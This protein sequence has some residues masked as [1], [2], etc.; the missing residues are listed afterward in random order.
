MAQG[1]PVQ[2][3]GVDLHTTHPAMLWQMSHIQNRG[4][5]AQMLAQGQSSLAKRGGLAAD[6]SSGL[7]FLKKKPGSSPDNHPPPCSFS[8]SHS[9]LF[10][11]PWTFMPSHSYLRAFAIAVPSAC[12]TYAPDIYMAPFSCPSNLCSDV[13][14]NSAFLITLFKTAAPPVYKISYL[15]IYFVDCLSS[16]SPTRM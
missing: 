11:I 3:P 5:W 6:V 15:L 8:S 2:I 10:V 16:P 13:F 7:I 9:G 14:L 1:S 4:R 12:N